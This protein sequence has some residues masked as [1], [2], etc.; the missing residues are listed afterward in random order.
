MQVNWLDRMDGN[1]DL[2]QNAGTAIYPIPA[3]LCRICFDA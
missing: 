2:A 3:F 1:Y